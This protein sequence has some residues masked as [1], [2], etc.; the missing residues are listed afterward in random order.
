[1]N[2]SPQAASPSAKPASSTA[3]AAAIS[4]EPERFAVIRRVLDRPATIH[5][6]IV[7][8]LL[9][10]LAILAL[11]A[12]HPLTGDAPLYD[13][14]ALRML[15]GQPIYPLVPPLVGW[16]LALFYRV[17][18]TGTLV[19]RVCMLPAY[20]GF[21]YSLYALGTRIAGRTA[22]NIAVLLFTISPLYSFLSLEPITELPATFFIV[23]FTL[24]LLRASADRPLGPS[25]LAGLTLGVLLLTRPS[26][27]SLVPFFPLYLWWRTKRF[28]AAVIGVAVPAVLVASYVVYLQRSTGH[29]AMIN[30]SSTQNVFLGNN[31]YTPLYRTWWFAS[32]HAGERG[33]PA[34]FS[35]LY[36]S[37]ERRPWWEQNKLYRDYA[38]RHISSHPGLF[39][40]R[41]LSRMR[42][43][44]AFDSYLGSLLR[45]RYD[46]SRTVAFGI[47]ALDGGLYCLVVGAAILFL[48]TL[49]GGWT[50]NAELLTVVGVAAAYGAPYCLSVSHPIYHFPIIPLLGVLAGALAAQLLSKPARSAL[51]PIYASAG[52]RVGLALAMLLFLY[53]QLEFAVVMFRNASY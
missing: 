43:Y 39:V 47:I 21:A 20:V 4:A 14:F 37:I 23:L 36:S 49:T 32:H 53:I 16:W 12:G 15:R 2:S 26:A 11:I 42:V 9:I 17:F 38:L 18:G 8:G 30:Y 33:V 25:V 35:A 48:F 41:T 5:W 24:F 19:A 10:R 28:S 44:L 7:F 6:L 1:M 45:N 31:E 52:R 13:S 50:K 27:M 40:V 29:F 22:A 46:T 51:A 34:E 3:S